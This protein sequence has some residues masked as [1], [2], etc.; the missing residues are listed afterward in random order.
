[1]NKI[2]EVDKMC[3]NCPNHDFYRIIRIANHT[4]H[5]KMLWTTQNNPVHP[6]NLN[7]I[8]VQTIIK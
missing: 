5:T 6:E 7:K 3:N 1:M 2:F 4:N 8:T